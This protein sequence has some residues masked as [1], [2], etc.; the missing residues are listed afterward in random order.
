MGRMDVNP[1]SAEFQ[2]CPFPHFRRLQA[3]TPVYHVPGTH[4]HFVTRHQDMVPLLRD[5]T[6][7]SN[8]FQ[9]GTMPN[10]E[11]A[12]RLRAVM[13][14]GWP[15]VPTMLTV[16]PPL[17]TRF[18]GT[19]APYFTPRRI[20]ELRP[21]VEQIVNR[22]IDSFVDGETMNFVARF[23]VPLPI[24]AIA[25]I[26]NVPAD[27]M[28]HFKRWSDA[29]IISI[30]AMPTDDERVEAQEHIVEF[31]HYFAEQLEQ[32]AAAE[33]Q[34]DLLS[35]LAHARIDDDAIGKDQG[36]NDAGG[37][38]AGGKRPLTMAE[39]L[40]ITSQLL[41]AGNE[42]TTKALTEGMRLLA[43]NPD[44]W[45]RLRADPTGRAPLVTEEVLRLA[46]PTQGMFR[47]VTKD[48]EVAGCPVKA[49]EW[50][51]LS[52]AAANRDVAVFG[53][54]PDAFDPDRPDLKDHLA[55]GKG[56]HFC[57]GA[58]LS[59]VEM[60]VAFELLARRLSSI[61]LLES[62]DFAYHPSFM[63][64]GLKKLDVRIRLAS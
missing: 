15:Q 22:L 40:G 20:A 13:K 21:E 5:T 2:Q 57:L 53:N 37:N 60:Q 27:R 31:Q 7:F 55:F 56:I 48:T 41:V 43:E 45:E 39:M 34:S 42:T 59:R 24:E 58:P 19:V 35:D 38:D 11:V 49:G 25:K 14:K 51:V 8:A 18:R 17:H 33:R 28:A 23:A 26:L 64:R 29:H 16:D 9:T 52:Y 46:T 63:L 30:G 12:D 61:E 10:S 44:Q 4:M 62:N 47:V 54:D 1:F 36:G 50:L 32:R 6:T 3:E